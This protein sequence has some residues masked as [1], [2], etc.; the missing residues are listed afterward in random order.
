MGFNQQEGAKFLPFNA[1]M[2]EEQ[3]ANAMELMRGTLDIRIDLPCF[4]HPLRCNG[5]R[6]TNRGICDRGQ[7]KVIW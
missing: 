1:G 2:K 7:M 6:M 4:R 5:G 3:T